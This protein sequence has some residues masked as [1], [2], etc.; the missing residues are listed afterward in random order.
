M[1]KIYRLTACTVLVAFGLVFG[2]Q[3]ARAQFIV[4]DPTNLVQS[5]LQYLQD[6]MR[7]GGMGIS[8]VADG[9]SKL[10][11]MRDQFKSA[12]E[13]LDQVY[14]IVNKFQ[15]LSAAASD[16]KAVVEVSK[17]ITDDILTF[18][19]IEYYMNNIGGYSAATRMGSL[20]NSYQKLALQLTDEIRRDMMDLQKITQTDPLTMLSQLSDRVEYLYGSYNRIRSAYFSAMRQTYLN[21]I[22][23]QICDANQVTMSTLYY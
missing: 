8:D 14:D 21:D 18:R 11:I 4:Q 23:E 15:G 12:Q 10:E 13:K 5:I 20:C 1:K 2:G 9:V 6:Q 7:E 22:N 3:K 19:N 17:L 16:I